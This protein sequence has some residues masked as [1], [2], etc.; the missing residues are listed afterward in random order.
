MNVGARVRINWPGN[1]VHHNKVGI[2]TAPWASGR[3]WLVDTD[4][5]LYAY[6]P[7]YL[8]KLE[9]TPEE[10]EQQRRQ[11]HAMRYL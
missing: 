5:G 1:S 4:V 2:I 9:L 6:F 11:D 7:S 10:Q 3:L 8:I